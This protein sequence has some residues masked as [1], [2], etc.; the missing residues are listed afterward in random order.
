LCNCSLATFKR[1]FSELYKESP[2]KY[3]L[4]KKLEKS[5]QL[6]LLESMPISEIA[7]ESG[8]ETFSNFNKVFKNTFRISIE[9]NHQLVELYR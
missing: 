6:L 5:K 1:K 7:Y 9:P 8:L 4:L 2:A 3:I